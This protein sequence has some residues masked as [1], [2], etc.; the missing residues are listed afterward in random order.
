[1]LTGLADQLLH[2]CGEFDKCEFLS[3]ATL[4]LGFGRRFNQAY[5]LRRLTLN[6]LHKAHVLR[7]NLKAAELIRNEIFLP[8]SHRCLTVRLVGTNSGEHVF[9]TFLYILQ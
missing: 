4:G 7:L 6:G 5:R 2:S 1:M 9:A 3:T 8:L